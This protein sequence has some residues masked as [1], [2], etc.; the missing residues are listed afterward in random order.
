MLALIRTL[1]FVSLFATGCTIL[2]TTQ[3]AGDTGVSPAPIAKPE[4]DMNLYELI[5]K[6]EDAAP[7]TLES[8][9]EI[10]G[11]RF[12]FSGS[13]NTLNTYL[14]VDRRL[15]LST[16][17]AIDNATVSIDIA[18]KIVTSIELPLVDSYGPFYSK[19]RIFETFGKEGFSEIGGD[20]RWDSVTTEKRY[21]GGRITFTT[22]KVANGTD[23]LTEVILSDVDRARK[24][25][26]KNLAP[27]HSFIDRVRVALGMGL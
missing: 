19:D 27:P 7:W 21:W 6:L 22:K 25:K 15:V 4:Q 16:S 5:Q 26:E 14:A 2:T 8:I 17:V 1:C 3:N 24:Q 10:L 18:T 12:E 9:S 23:Y 20:G 11:T 13:T